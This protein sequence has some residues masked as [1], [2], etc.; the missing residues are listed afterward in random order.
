[1]GANGGWNT[2]SD[3]LFYEDESPARASPI[4]VHAMQRVANG[5]RCGRRSQA[6]V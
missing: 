6:Y 2:V 5:Y 3:V 4:E 1:M